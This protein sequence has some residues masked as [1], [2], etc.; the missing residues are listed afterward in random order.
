[1]NK[2]LQNIRMLPASLTGEKRRLL[3]VSGYLGFTFFL[4]YCFSDLAAVLLLPAGTAFLWLLWFL[5]EPAG[6]RP[7]ADI[8]DIKPFSR[9]QPLLILAFFFT[10]VAVLAAGIALTRCGLDFFGIPYQPEQKLIRVLKR[11]SP[12]V[13]IMIGLTTSILS[14]FGEEIVFRKI[15]FEHLRPRGTLW[16]VI[17][18][19]A[20]FSVLHF[21]LAGLLALALF[22]VI[23]QLLFL[24]T[25]N[26]RC[27]ITLHTVFN[28][29]MFFSS[30]CKTGQAT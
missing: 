29:L 10:T 15:I 13:K 12:M 21:Y 7:L 20:L 11:S 23:L 4:P 14:P 3:A 18:T 25:G 28:L 30:I 27:S 16:A 17:L 5:R 26:L 2:R 9:G 8:L 24:K 22:G 6:E 19:S 1:M